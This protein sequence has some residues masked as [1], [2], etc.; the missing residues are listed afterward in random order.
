M[1]T[2]LDEVFEAFRDRYKGLSIKLRYDKQLVSELIDAT[3]FLPEDA[4]LSERVWYYKEGLH[5]VQMCPYCN[6]H[7]RKFYKVDKGLQATCGSDQCRKAG[8]SKGA[9][10]ERDW[11]AIQ[12]KMRATYKERTGYEHNMQNPEFIAK[13]KEEFAK[14]H[15]GIVCGVQTEKA[16]SNLQK[17]IDE[18]Y[19]GSV[20]KMLENGMIQKYGSLSNAASV[21]SKERGL[22]AR[23]TRLAEVISRLDEMDFELVKVDCQSYY[24]KCRKCGL[25]QEIS[26]YGIM[27]N[28][29]NGRRF[30]RKCDYKN[31]TY[32]SNFERSIGDFISSIYEGD[33]W[34]NRQKLGV[35]CD[36]MIPDK[37]IAIEAN[38]IYYHSELFKDKGSHYE[39][40]MKVESQGWSLIQI[41]EDD[42]N[43]SIKKDII[44]SRLVSKLGMSKRLFARKCQIREVSGKDA[45]AFLSENHLQGYV[46]SSFNFGLYHDSELVE[47][48]TFGRSRKVISGNNE[49]IE[50]YRLCTKK[51]LN[52]IGGFSKL[53]K[54]AMNVFNTTIISYADCDWCSSISNGYENVGF[55]KVKH[56]GYDYTWEVDGIRKNRLSFTKKKLISK[57]MDPSKTEDEIMHELGH[58]KVYG[59]GNY[60]FELIPSADT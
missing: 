52:V 3:S 16:K 55:T 8:M 26:R 25:I 41:W 2:Y 53:I 36:I 9:K 34:Y 38:G 56:T 31:M 39:K 51:G 32:R 46:A 35:E 47:I 24:V 13:A 14:K 15:N 17:V 10:A 1:A 18:K 12:A 33:I 40:K 22:K 23:E 4:S 11:D 21:H 59:T 20:R 29:R 28:Y 42:W 43:D 60:L 30:C 54:Y 37:K 50:L 45:K 6:E 49:S 58:K 57:G 5:E 27:Y 19:D 48:A 7:R 44:K